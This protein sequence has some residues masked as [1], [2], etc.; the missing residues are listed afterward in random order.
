MKYA[1]TRKIISLILS[2]CTVLGIF[3]LMIAQAEDTSDHAR[4]IVA[5]GIDVSVWQEKIDWKKVKADGIEFAIL[6]AGYTGA[7]DRF[8]EE[9]Y[10]KAKAEGIELGCYFYT[11]AVTVAEAEKD[12]DLLISWLEGKKFEYPIYYDMEDNKQ[13]AEEMTTELRTQMCLAFLDKM[14][15]AGYYTGLYANP[16]WFNNYL[17]EAALA[18]KSQIWLASWTGSGRPTIDY[19]DKYG[20]WQYSATGTVDGI[21]G[22]VDMNVAFKDYPA[23][24]KR[25]GYN[26]Y[27]RGDSVKVDEEWI[28]T[29]DNVNVRAGAGTSYSKVGT[30][31]ANKRIHVTEKINDG[32][33]SWGKFKSGSLEGWCALNY[34]KKT[35]STLKSNNSKIKIKD[36]MIIGLEP[37]EEVYDNLFKVSGLAKIKTEQTRYGFGTGT[38]INLVLGETVVNT[39][40]V[41]IGGDING[42]CVADSFDL[43]HSI[44]ITNFELEY[45]ETSPQFLASDLNSDGV[46]DVYDSNLLAEIVNFE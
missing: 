19:S 24:I 1:K 40:Y 37:G 15:K 27:T 35:T 41:V 4:S 8:F 28:I 33:Y 7:K 43:V 20:L 26:G 39:Y 23:I 38:K 18:E 34:A 16:L 36:K 2:I 30:L 31:N 12:A 14:E 5:Y 17:D 44:A 32:T 22:N 25:G 42:D 13:L 3:G 45:E 10:A 21:N 6:R 46:C 11:Y 9:N 29:E